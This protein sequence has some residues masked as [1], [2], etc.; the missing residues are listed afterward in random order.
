[1]PRY[2]MKWKNG[3]YGKKFSAENNTAAKN[4]A[5]AITKNLKKKI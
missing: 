3:S 4:R 1:M 5:R 2:I